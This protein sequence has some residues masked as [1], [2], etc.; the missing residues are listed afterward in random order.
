MQNDTLKKSVH[1]VVRYFYPVVAGIET[2][3][4][5]VYESLQKGDW[6]VTIHTSNDTP[7][8][9]KSLEPREMVKNLSV[10]RY[11]W[12]WYGFVPDIPWKSAD[13]VALHNFDI[14][15]HSWLLTRVLFARF[16]GKKTPKIF[17]IP[18]GGFTPGWWTFPWHQRLVKQFYQRFLGVFLINHTVDA[19][20]SVSEWERVETVK[21]GVRDDL[22]VTIQNGLEKEAFTDVERLASD[23]IRDIVT[24]LGTYIVQVGRI[25]PI[26]NQL[27]T[28]KALALVKDNVRF[29]I[30]GPVTDPEYKKLLDETIQR[31]NLTD[32]VRFLGVV[33]GIDK[34]YLL[35]HSLANVH[36][37]SWESYCNAM[38][39]SM[40]QGCICVVAR[41]T[42]S[43][44]LIQD[45]VN[46]YAVG[47]EDSQAV[48]EKIEFILKNGN[49]EELNRMR[50]SN[51]AFTKEHA[52]EKIAERVDVLYRS[53]WTKQRG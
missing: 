35:K 31:L 15:P 47:V 41:D 19:Y 23:T 1:V 51:I 4:L 30:A 39:E 10:K 3:I 17:L 34:Y 25:H 6:E 22:V 36:M 49:S 48:A 45:G 33:G 27:T 24:S 28:I 9:K 29:A 43:E 8:A 7:S 2:N 50:L 46:G 16:L 12:R 13:A 53:A 42:A 37:A 40:S 52:W 5:N 14:F 18:H 21:H 44:E 11:P 32:R 20:R 38:H 26:K